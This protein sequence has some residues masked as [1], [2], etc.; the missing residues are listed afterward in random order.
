MFALAN[1]TVVGPDTC[2]QV[3][4]PEAGVLPDI[5][6]LV[7]AHSVWLLPAS[8]VVTACST[9][10]VILLDVCSG[11]TPL[12][13]FAWYIVVADRFRK[14]C[15]EVVLMISVQVVPPSTDDSHLTTL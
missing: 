7:T 3:P 8:G 15:D 6:A 5:V 9:V 2:V 4:V 12:T 1:V 11:H 10:M 13:T 14:L